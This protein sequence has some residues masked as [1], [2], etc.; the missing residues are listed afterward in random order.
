MS[1]TQQREFLVLSVVR[2]HPEHGYA[3][4]ESLEQG[5]GQ[6][7]AL[8]RSTVYAILKRFVER[9]W[10]VHHTMKTTNYPER[11]VYELT[12]AGDKAYFTLL[13]QNLHTTS[14]PILPL[15]I[16][17]AH[18]DDLQA[19]EQQQLLSH[20]KNELL[21]QI[22]ALN[23]IPDH[24]GVAAIAMNLMRSHVAADLSAIEFLLEQVETTTD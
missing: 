7:L 19:D 15:V 13:R 9:G 10:V 20:Y 1:L 4:A 21:Q 12:N 17:L 2:A 6:A 11:Q 24:A 5:L 23:A 8:K 22:D 18:L 14:A 3:L 16:V